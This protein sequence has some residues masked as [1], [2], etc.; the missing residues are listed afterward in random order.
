MSTSASPA[1]AGTSD[2]AENMT[3]SIRPAAGRTGRTEMGAWA[4]LTATV[5]YGVV[6]V[7]LLIKK[8]WPLATCF[9]CYTIANV[10]YLWMGYYGI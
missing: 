6:A 10:A 3:E 4:L 9:V 8:D 1:S 7:D 2:D 5:L